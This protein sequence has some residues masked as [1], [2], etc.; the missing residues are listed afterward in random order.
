MA[1]LAILAFWFPIADDLNPDFS[2]LLLLTSDYGIFFCP[3]T[4]VVLA[5]L[6]IIYPRLNPGLLTATSLV[7]LIF[8]LFN[9]MTLFIVPEYTL[10]MF[11]LHLPLILISLYGLTIGK[12][13][14]SSP[15]VR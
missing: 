8:G 6:T 14:S 11:V 5:V 4:P 10:W 12:F 1:P 13:V 7:G 3:T 9:A 2:P 15:G